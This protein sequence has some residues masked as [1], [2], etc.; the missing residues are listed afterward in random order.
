MPAAGNS[1]QARGPSHRIAI[2][3]G[4]WTVR[5]DDRFPLGTRT[6]EHAANI[7]DVAQAAGVAVPTVYKL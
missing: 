7:T 5:W 3:T 1:H 2:V 4:G 6:C